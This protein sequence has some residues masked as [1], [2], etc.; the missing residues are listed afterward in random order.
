[1]LSCLAN[2]SR[3]ALYCESEI[4]EAIAPFKLII[5]SLRFDAELLDCA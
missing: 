1:M 5:A 2:S 3:S 4:W